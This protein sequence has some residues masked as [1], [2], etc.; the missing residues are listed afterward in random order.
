MFLGGYSNKEQRTAEPWQD[1]L[2][3]QERDTVPPIVHHAEKLGYP[4]SLSADAQAAQQMAAKKRYPW[5]VDE[6]LAAMPGQ[7]AVSAIGGRPKDFKLAVEA[8]PQEEIAQRLAAREQ[9]DAEA[10]ADL[11]EAPGEKSKDQ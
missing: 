7:E 6:Y 4:V 9:A 10:G 1:K 5:T 2:P 11:S 8:P 3:I